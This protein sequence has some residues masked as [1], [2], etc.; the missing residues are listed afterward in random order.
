MLA[1]AHTEDG[2]IRRYARGP[3]LITAVRGDKQK[4]FTAPWLGMQ[5][6]MAITDPPPLT[7]SPVTPAGALRAGLRIR[8]AIRSEAHRARPRRP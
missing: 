7:I 6:P 4:P 1:E 8:H 3:G 2:R 5:L